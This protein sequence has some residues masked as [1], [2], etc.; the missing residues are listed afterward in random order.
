M[1]CEAGSPGRYRGD[2]PLPLNSVKGREARRGEPA[3]RAVRFHDSL[4]SATAQEG[5]SAHPL[6][7]TVNLYSKNG[8]CFW[9]ELRIT[10]HLLNT[11]Q[12]TRDAPP[13]QGGS[14]YD[15]EHT[16]NPADPRGRGHLGS[17]G[18]HVWEGK[19]VR[20][21]WPAVWRVLGKPDTKL[22]S[23]PAI[24]APFTAAH[25]AA[26]A[27]GNAP[28]PPMNDGAS[29][30]WCVPTEPHHGALGRKDISTC[31]SA[32]TNRE[33]VTDAPDTE[34]AAG[35]HSREALDAVKFTE[36]EVDMAARS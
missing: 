23:D 28:G 3:P 30:A 16:E 24:P 10:N 13:T 26:G 21:P 25:A 31:V 6:P 5:R 36:T 33:D 22:R 2:L 8:V 34:G 29:K 7:E 20:P 19:P 32:W 35:C 4:R 9:K 17:T 1:R 15:I 14:C 12:T 18:C 11:S 27:G